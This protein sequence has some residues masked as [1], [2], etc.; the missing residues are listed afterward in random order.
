VS[1]TRSARP[2]G[3]RKRKCEANLHAARGQP[4]NGHRPAEINSR[5]QAGLQSAFERL[6]QSEE[7]YRQI[8]EQSPEGILL[9]RGGTILFANSACASFFG[10]PWADGMVGKQIL[11]WVHPCHREA[12]KQRIQRH[13]LDFETVRQNETTFLRLDGKEAYA[14]VVACSVMYRGESAAQV[15]LRDISLRKEAEE[16]FY[17]AFNANP[18]PMTIASASEG[19][20]L[21][22]NESF[23]RVTGY[24][25]EEVIGRT[26]LELN[27][28][29]RP[30]DRAKLIEIVEKE[31]S[32]R[33][34]EITFLTK[35]RDRRTALDSAE[36]V[37]LAGQKCILAIFK[38]ITEKKILEQ[39]R[40]QAEE[41]LALRAADLAR[42]NA[43]LAQFAYVASHDLQEP[44]RMVASYTQLLA[45]RY[46]DKLDADA[47]DFIGYAVDGA[48][49]MQSLITELLNYS[50]VGT[51]GKAFQPV[52]CETILER[53]L[54]VLKLA[55][56][57]SGAM[58]SHD[59]LPTVMGDEMQL[60]QLFQNLVANALKFRRD[61]PPQ[62]HVSAERHEHAWQFSVR[63]NGI[64]ISPDHAERI[65]MIFQRLHSRSEY[66]G[67]GIGLAICKKIV[68]R[69][70]GRIWLK[71][72][73]GNGAT[74]FFTIPD[75]KIRPGEARG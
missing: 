58:V 8:V 13:R 18:E 51:Q 66:P 34:L 10:V 54:A 67:T 53:V 22:V 7:T 36:I 14:E 57:E 16:R 38:D 21:D 73:P 47:R 41:A 68:E 29:E 3:S 43:E 17:K 45:K 5:K 2:N 40:D 75:D 25:R 60:S 12:V 19:Y 44:L 11:D 31:G 6:R 15:T 52:N 71:S 59:P 23:L 24:S 20:Y 55:M 63:D 27:F 33:D 56:N 62:V 48:T 42:S 32:V 64:G 74:F 65:F 35:S 49:R 37:E 46:G 26:S 72:Q 61:T 69:H 70:C 9:H 28:W 4:A 30:E 50:R 39:Q 1:K